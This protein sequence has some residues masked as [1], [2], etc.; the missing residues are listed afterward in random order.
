M[1]V[2]AQPVNCE[3]WSVSKMSGPLFRA[4]TFPRAVTQMSAFI[5][6]DGH[7]TRLRPPHWP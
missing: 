5:V 2:K 7:Q 3:L 4:I 1:I 6:F